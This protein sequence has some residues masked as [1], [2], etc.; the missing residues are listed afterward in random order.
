MPAAVLAL[1]TQSCLALTRASCCCS[2]QSDNLPARR[3]SDGGD[4][5]TVE[6]A[7][8]SLLLL[9]SAVH[10]TQLCACFEASACAAPSVGG[11]GAES[12]S[13]LL[14]GLRLCEHG[15]SGECRCK[16][17][18]RHPDCALNAARRYA[19]P[20]CGWLGCVCVSGSCVLTWRGA[21]GRPQLRG[22]H[23]HRERLRRFGAPRGGGQQ[24]GHGL[25]G[26][27]RAGALGL[28][29]P[30]RSLSAGLVAV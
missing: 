18:G 7:V 8:T 28:C 11:A 13:V 23:W 29:W 30:R 16:D 26:V 9:S 1:P 14:P 5:L 15:C 3:A 27:G 21:R 4:K 12:A 10:A 24:R 2:F 19:G 22:P 6:Y 20:V 17:P 25:R